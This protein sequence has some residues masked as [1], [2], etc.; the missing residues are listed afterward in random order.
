MQVPFHPVVVHFPLAVTFVM[1]VLVFIFAYMIKLNKM[2]PKGWLI[3]VGLQLAVVIS[4][5]V[6]LET[7]ETEEDKVEKVLDK[8]YIHE[9]EESAEIFVGSTV[10]AL[11]LSVAAFFIR[12]DLGHPIKLSMG[13]IGLICCFLAYR[14]GHLGGEI[15][16]KHGGAAA[17]LEESD[18]NQRD[19]KLGVKEN[20]TNESLKLDENDYGNSDEEENLRDEDFKQED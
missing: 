16:Y 3:I 6:A 15:L 20:E 18:L 5:Y 10:I 2:N 4:G 12:K 1:P 17:Y 13:F 9:H 19:S 7:G 8:T 14:A 11:V